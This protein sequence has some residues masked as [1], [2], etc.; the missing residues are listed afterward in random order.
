[1]E[2]TIS[3]AASGDAKIAYARKTT[4]SHDTIFPIGGDFISS[5][6][7]NLW[8]GLPHSLILYHKNKE[9]AIAAILI[10]MKI[11]LAQGNPESKYDSTR[12]N[13][14]FEALDFYAAQHEL[15][16]QPKTKFQALIAETAVG[17]EKLLLVKPTTYYNETGVSARTLIDFYKCD[18]KR[19]V[20]IVHDD[21]ALP[22]G[23]LRIREKGSDAG[24]NGIKSL[25]AHLGPDYARLRIGVGNDLRD[26]IADVD[27]VLAKFTKS[28]NEAL[29]KT[30]FSEISGLIDRFVDGELEPT[31]SK[32]I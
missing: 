1:M 7:K 13:V 25:N 30:I 22:F 29:G 24:N 2:P 26:K 17:D 8:A 18:P 16:F 10:R 23:T 12:H 4:T 14:G 6:P 20:L 11:I 15:V 28:E 19:D 3:A 32:H 5:P 31:S 9:K 27:F 21:L